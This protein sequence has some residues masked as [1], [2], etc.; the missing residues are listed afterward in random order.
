MKVY[1]T[2]SLRQRERHSEAYK[3]IIKDLQHRGHLVFEKVLSPHLQRVPEISERYIKEW[4]KEWNSY[5][6]DCDVAVIEGSHSSTIHIGFETGLIL[7]RNKPVIL[8]YRGGENPIFINSFYS[9][10]LIKSEYSDENI[11]EVLDWCFHEL[12]YIVN[13]R[14]TFFVSPEIDDFL[15]QV[16]RRDG[17]SR[18]EYIRFLI[19]KEMK[20]QG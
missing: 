9:S 8:L 10:K 12:E 11:K 13:R 4:Y 14:F 20:R 19:E 17:I 18:A 15:D 5:V 6:S 3:A 7:A 16:V 1:F 2:A